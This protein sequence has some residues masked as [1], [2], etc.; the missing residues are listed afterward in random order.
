M[1]VVQGKW[2]CR[3][4]HKWSPGRILEDH[5][6]KGSWMLIQGYTLE[7]LLT[8]RG[9]SR[10]FFFLETHTWRNG[11]H[12]Y[13]TI[14]NMQVDRRITVKGID[15]LFPKVPFCG[16]T[17]N[18]SNTVLSSVKPCEIFSVVF[19]FSFLYLIVNLSLRPCV[20]LCLFQHLLSSTFP[21]PFYLALL[22][23]IFWCCNLLFK[24][25]S[26]CLLFTCLSLS[27]SW[28]PW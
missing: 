12:Q 23:S 21:I 10:I 26:F 3:L 14:F 4:Q 17:K 2:I 6:H 8:Y 11:K 20:W 9:S 22:I 27:S 7:Q 13:C 25:I 1:L 16:T 28:C 19:C 15:Q 5:L 24:K 18:S